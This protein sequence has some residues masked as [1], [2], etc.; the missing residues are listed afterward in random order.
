MDQILPDGKS[1][2]GVSGRCV[3]AGDID[4][5]W[6]T[7]GFSDRTTHKP[8]VCQRPSFAPSIQCDEAVSKASRVL[9]MLRWSFP[10]LSVSEFSSALNMLRSSARLIIWLMPI[11]WGKSN[12]WRRG[13][14]P[15][16]IWGTTA[17]V[18]SALSRQASHPWRPHSRTK[19]RFLEDW[20]WTPC[21][22]LATK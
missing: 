19:K 4:Q 22:N 17:S 7:S 5:E 21:V 12:V 10:E 13:F 1:L 18:E 14:S 6:G 20:I 2:Q 15:P 11:V 3:V 9:F 8:V 16:S